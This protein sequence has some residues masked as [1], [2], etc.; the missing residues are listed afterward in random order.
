MLRL[1]FFAIPLFELFGKVNR[2]LQTLESSV[3]VTSIS[4]VRQTSGHWYFYR[5]L[6][7]LWIK[8]RI[9]VLSQIF[10]SIIFISLCTRWNAIFYICYRQRFIDWCLIDSSKCFQQIIINLCLNRCIYLSLIELWGR[11]NSW[12]N[13]CIILLLNLNA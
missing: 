6:F 11:L 5:R 4:N 7:L 12:A 13:N 3:Y 10:L 9:L 2:F 1:T 8:L